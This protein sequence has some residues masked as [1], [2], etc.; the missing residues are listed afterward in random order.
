[1]REAARVAGL[2]EWSRQSKLR[3][4]LAGIEPRVRAHL[5]QHAVT[6]ENQQV[7]M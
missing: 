6:R 1:M 5:Q 7:S 2:S 3:Y 4:H